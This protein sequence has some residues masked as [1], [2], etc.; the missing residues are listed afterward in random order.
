MDLAVSTNGAFVGVAIFRNLRG[1]GFE[2]LPLP[3]EFTEAEA[4][5][6]ADIDGDGAQ[7]LALRHKFAGASVLFNDGDGA[8]PVRKALAGENGGAW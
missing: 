8:F 3:G 1:R 7:D 4:L 2:R 5:A 6:A